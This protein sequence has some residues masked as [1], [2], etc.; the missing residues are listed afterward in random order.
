M[1]LIML[2]AAALTL[3][4][5]APPHAVKEI[6]IVYSAWDDLPEL[7]HETSENRFEDWEE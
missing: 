2:I 1:K 3:A 5:C 4:G 7:E 6:I